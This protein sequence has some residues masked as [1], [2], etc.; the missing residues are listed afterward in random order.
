M[1]AKS[2][3]ILMISL[4]LFFSCKNEE[5]VG[6]TEITKW[7]YGK[8]AA[9]SLTYDDGTIN[10]FRKALPLMDSL[11]F[12]ATFYI[13]T[14]NI[15]GA[16]YNGA[17]IGRPVAEI[18]EETATVPTNENNLFERASA[19]GFL[20]LQGTLQY[21]TQAG[22]LVDQGKIEE[23][24]KVI[25]EAYQ[26]VRAKTF[27]SK[28]SATDDPTRDRLTWEEVR[29]VAANGHEFGSHTI[30]HPRL[31]VLDE[32]NLLYELE[33]S[34]EEIIKQIGTEHTFSA[35]C[36]YGTENERVMEYALK[37][38]PSLRNRMPEPYL[39][40]LNRWAENT[41]GSSAK[42]YVQWQRGPH[43]DTPMET[44]KSWVDTILTHDNNWLV[45]VFHGVEGIGWQA[46]PITEFEEY[47]AYMK[48]KEGDLWITTFRDATK[49]M[50]EKM[51][52]T[53]EVANENGN[54]RIALKNDLEPTMYNI[55]LT[56]KTYV[57]SGWEKIS[58][59]QGEIQ[60]S[61]TPKKDDT[62]SFVLYQANPFGQDIM[63]SEGE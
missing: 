13:I 22:E 29:Q 49:Y 42:S 19:I 55:A 16:T 11:G 56:L 45:L 3:F 43:T 59:A 8:K 54:I 61:Y 30:T 18:I 63:I 27:P 40:E 12:P 21:H 34:K 37:I 32:T 52:T 14:G 6:Q 1:M 62:G 39:E 58:V 38:Y 5:Y 28:K 36:P 7:Q 10:Q 53:V 26:K 33:K 48:E 24:C 47:F 35:E 51:N 60:Q 31:A 4:L 17:F 25:N 20:G 41:P 23:A 15:P 57:P 9:V 44:M 50:R 46:K 2:I